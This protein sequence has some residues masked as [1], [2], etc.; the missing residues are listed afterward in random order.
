MTQYRGF[1]PKPATAEDVFAA[2]ER[3]FPLRTSPLHAAQDCR[4][5]WHRE[6][7]HIIVYR[8]NS[9]GTVTEM[10]SKVKRSVVVIEA[11]P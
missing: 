10:E 8:L 5:F 7:Q 6:G 1:Y 9:D 4:D 11:A 2:D 3:T